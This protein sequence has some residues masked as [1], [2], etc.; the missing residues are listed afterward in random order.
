MI[1]V[2]GL[3][4][5]VTGGVLEV[6]PDGMTPSEQLAAIHN[7]LAVH[8]ARQAACW[9]QDLLPKLQQAGIRLQHYRDL[10]PQQ[11]A[12]LRWYFEREVLPVLTRSPLI[13][14]PL[15]AY[16]EPQFNLAVVVNDPQRGERFARVK[17]EDV[18]PRL[19]RIPDEDQAQQYMQRG[20]TE[21]LAHT[22]VWM[23]EIIAAHLDMLFP[24][25]RGGGV[26]VSRHA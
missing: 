1:R 9:Q 4:R 16:V 6:P 14:R 19:V 26:S 13:R 21:G 11:R 18:L 8:L 22:F 3:R 17:V 25:L 24:G 5:Q 7:T 15:S 23:E 10:Q 12:F 2:S 20:L